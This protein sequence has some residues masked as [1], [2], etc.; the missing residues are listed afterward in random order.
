MKTTPE[1]ARELR[2]TL[3]QVKYACRLYKIEPTTKIGSANCWDEAGI[4]QIRS[5]LKRI[6]KPDPYYANRL[7]NL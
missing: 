1:V 7:K 2:A 3:E 6:D 5:A 4:E